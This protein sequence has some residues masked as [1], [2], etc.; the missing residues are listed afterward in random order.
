MPMQYA[1][2]FRGCKNDIL[3]EKKTGT[4]H[5]FA[6]NIECGYTVL[7]ST[8][9]KIRNRVYPC[10]YQFY[11]IKVG[12]KGSTLHGHVSMMAGHFWVHVK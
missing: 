7:T 4:F 2:I 1:A 9:S 10:K 6:K 11:Y 8:N 5:I 3:A 12:C